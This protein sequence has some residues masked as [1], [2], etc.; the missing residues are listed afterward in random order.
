MLAKSG[1]RSPSKS[2]IANVKP[3]PSD[4]AG[5]SPGYAQAAVAP[6]IKPKNRDR[7][8][9]RSSRCVPP[10]DRRSLLLLTVV[11]PFAWTSQAFAAQASLAALAACLALTVARVLIVVSPAARAW[12]AAPA[13]SEVLNQGSAARLAVGSALELDLVWCPD[14]ASDSGSD[15]ASY[16]DSAAALAAGWAVAMDLAL[17]RD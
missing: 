12:P 15:L 10:F 17:Y 6:K 11:V 2:A 9:N 7:I 16:P 8:M 14:S 4:V 3:G 5:G 1:R 13:W